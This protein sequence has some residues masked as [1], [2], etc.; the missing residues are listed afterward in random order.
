MSENREDPGRG[1]RFLTSAEVAEMVGVSPRTVSNWIRDGHLK[2]F[3]TPGGHGRVA[4]ED[5]KHF[6][7]ERGI[8]PL[9]VAANGP[10]A[11]VGAA[12][13]PRVLFI[14]DDEN[15]L[16]I[17]REVLEANGFEVQTARHG[18]LAGYLVAHFQPQA[19]VLDLM[20]PGLDGF[21]VLSLM[22]KRPEARALPVI[23]CTS[24][25]GPD[26]EGRA[27]EAGFAAYIKKPLDFRALVSLLREVIV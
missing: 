15:L 21:E 24:L 12:R 18:F 22:R 2:A 5:L 23:A 26:A 13:P 10:L 14:D 7:D 17:I 19:I 27:R 6:L 11:S 16:D 3:R 8:R 4:E 1:G 20:M 9:P 25:R